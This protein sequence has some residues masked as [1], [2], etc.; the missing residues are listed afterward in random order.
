MFPRLYGE[1]NKD[2]SIGNLS[3]IKIVGMIIPVLKIKNLGCRKEKRHNTMS[4]RHSNSSLHVEIEEYCSY[5]SELVS[6]S[7]K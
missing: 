7:G 6:Y 1:V 4:I 2:T 3:V 5:V